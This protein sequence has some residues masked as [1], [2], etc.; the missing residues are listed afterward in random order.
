MAIEQ[1]VAR[2]QTAFLEL[3]AELSDIS[4]ACQVMG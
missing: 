1:K 3:A 2:R 4:R